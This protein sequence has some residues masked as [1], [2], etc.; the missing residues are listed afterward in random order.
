[1]LIFDFNL[2]RIIGSNSFA[3]GRAPVKAST[4]LSLF[5]RPTGEGL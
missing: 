5:P 1:M 4:C 2:L 3:M